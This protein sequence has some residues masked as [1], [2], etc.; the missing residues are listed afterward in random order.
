MMS[1][2]SER[3][4]LDLIVIFTILSVATFLNTSIVPSSA[5]TVIPN[6]DLEE[7]RD[8]LA[9]SREELQKGSL[10]SALQHINQADQQL[11]ALMSNTTSSE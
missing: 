9:E 6:K 4:E 1:T 7:V 3:I 8:N 11:L 5:Q 10:T 2:L